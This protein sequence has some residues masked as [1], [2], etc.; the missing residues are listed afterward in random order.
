M[1]ALPAITLLC[2]ASAMVHA[3][4]VA[5]TFGMFST[6][7]EHG[8]AFEQAL[9]TG[10][11]LDSLVL[12]GK[13]LDL[14]GSWR[15]YQRGYHVTGVTEA[16]T[17]MQT[18]QTAEGY[19]MLGR[20][21]EDKAFELLYLN[22]SLTPRS[23]SEYLGSSPA[24]CAQNSRFVFQDVQADTRSKISCLAIT[25]SQL[26]DNAGGQSAVDADKFT[27]LAKF[28]RDNALY[29]PG[30]AI[31]EQEMFLSRNASHFYVYRAKPVLGDGIE[32]F[33]REVLQLRDNVQKNFF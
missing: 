22:M 28:V 10:T 29:A 3:T 5:V 15:V 27:G 4:E 32:P 20:S 13:R 17:S 9:P 30:S 33:R 8:E 7:K 23:G 25:Q 21:G 31:Y 2:L 12:A 14:G 18:R 24:Y 26:A 19:L 16:G 1:K 11:E 6:A